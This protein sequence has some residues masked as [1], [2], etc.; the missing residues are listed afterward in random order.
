[1]TAA[2]RI[3]ALAACFLGLTGVFAYSEESGLERLYTVYGIEVDETARTAAEARRIAI[4][5]A[6]D[7]AFEQ[8]VARLISEEARLL[9]A[10]PERADPSDYLLGFEVVEEKNSPV[11]YI[12]TLNIS[13]DPE[14]MEQL[15]GLQDIAY[16]AITP[17]PALVFPL[18]WAGGGWLLWEEENAFREAWREHGGG[19]HIVDLR[20][21]EGALSERTAVTPEQLLVGR[22]KDRLMELA[23]SYGAGEV[24]VAAA[25]IVGDTFGRTTRL[26]IDLTTVLGSG[27]PLSLTVYPAPDESMEELLARGVETVLSRLDYE[28]KQRALSRFGAFE[29]IALHIPAE[30]GAEWA[31]LL[32]RLK[33]TPVVREV[34]VRRLSL[35]ESLVVVRYQGTFEQ[36]RLAL[37]Q[38][39]LVLFSSETGYGLVRRE[40]LRGQQ[41]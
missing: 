35:P 2:V 29:E 33:R 4:Q 9:F 14:K 28:W 30:T 19:N 15:F 22:Q 38:Q 6:Q 27:E 36:L 1:M 7:K 8:L 26:E 13:F 3:I 23:A 41:D 34:K 32:D 40:A 12:A 39:G 21:P 18:Q 17:E 5:K 16:V 37:E 24:K 31:A 10:L 11:R 20:L 25:R